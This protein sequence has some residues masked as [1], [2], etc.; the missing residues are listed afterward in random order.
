[1][2]DKKFASTARISLSGNVVSQPTNSVLINKMSYVLGSNNFGPWACHL[3]SEKFLSFAVAIH[4]GFHCS[5]L[6]PGRGMKNGGVRFVCYQFLTY[7]KQ[8][9]IFVADESY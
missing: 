4:E 7:R 3:A 5:S 9:R 6:G 1:M 8:V 2:D